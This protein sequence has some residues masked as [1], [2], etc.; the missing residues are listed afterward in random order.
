MK[1]AA[2]LF[3]IALILASNGIALIGVARNR[4]GEPLAT[5]E[6]TE[7]ELPLM[8][9]G[10]DNSGIDLSI[11]VVQNIPGARRRSVESRP[12]RANRFSISGFRQARS[13]RTLL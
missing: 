5:I 4:A 1:R 10:M 7:R 9:I 3:A 8:N 2:L 13:A 6:L 11:H 12:A